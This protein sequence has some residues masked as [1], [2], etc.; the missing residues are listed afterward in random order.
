MINRAISILKKRGVIVFAR[1][2]F[3]RLQGILADRAK[4]FNVYQYLFLEKSGIEIGGPS[5]VF[6]EGGIFPVYP[7]LKNLENVNFSGT[8]AWQWNANTPDTFV[9]DHATKAGK[10]HIA[11]AT[12]ITA[13]ATGVYDFVLSSHMLEHTANPIGA[14]TEW[15]RL[16]KDDGALLLVLPNKRFTFDHRRPVTS[17]EHMIA[18][19]NAGTEEDDL[20][21]LPEVLALHDF[22]RDPDV[23]DA[24][25]FKNRCLNNISNRCMHHHVFDKSLVIRLIQ[26]LGMTVKDVEEI[27][28]HHILVLAQKGKAL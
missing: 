17:L 12:S 18:D 21:H 20:T 28:P 9:Y 5:T 19:F 7:I 6:S 15:M 16:L 22:R 25:D 14:L 3:V 4:S 26:F 2:A 24:V 13:F 23:G 10:Q 27:A 11:E 8:T 1:A